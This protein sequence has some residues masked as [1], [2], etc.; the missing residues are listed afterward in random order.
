MH[1]MRQI[2]VQTAPSLE[3]ERIYVKPT[4]LPPY[5]I[6]IKKCPVPLEQDSS[7]SLPGTQYHPFFFHKVHILSISKS[8]QTQYIYTQ[9][10]IGMHDQRA[11]VC[12]VDVHK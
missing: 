10:R 5:L 6:M 4:Y 8:P 7:T 1:A 9:N 11:K 2:P 3:R 12:V